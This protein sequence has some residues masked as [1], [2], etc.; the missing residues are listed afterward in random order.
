MR[1]PVLLAACSLF[2][3]VSGGW[4]GELAINGSWAPPLDRALMALLA[5][6]AMLIG[7]MM[8][9]VAAEELKRG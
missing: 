8:A 1:S 7:W 5:A 4:L 6:A 9:V 2:L 3:L